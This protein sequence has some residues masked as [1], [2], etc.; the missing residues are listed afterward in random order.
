[1]AYAHTMSCQ[2]Q[3]HPRYQNGMALTDGEGLERVWSYLGNYVSV[4]RQMTSQRR[5]CTLDNAIKHFR[6][7]R[8]LSM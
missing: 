7:K 6:W 4:T 5:Q 1:H 8:L 3:Y 2:V